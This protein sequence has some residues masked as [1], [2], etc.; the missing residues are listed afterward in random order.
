MKLSV[1]NLSV[2]T[3]EQDLEEMVSQAGDVRSCRVV[4]ERDTGRSRGFASV[5]YRP[6]ADGQ[7]ANRQLA[8]RDSTGA[9][10]PSTRRSLRSSAGW[11]ASARQAGIAVG[12]APCAGMRIDS[13]GRDEP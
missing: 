5:E 4:T 2:T 11:N 3:S 12:D 7:A 6:D 9:P 13:E 1:G 10:R 8:G